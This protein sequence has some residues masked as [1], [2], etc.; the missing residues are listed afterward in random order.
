MSQDLVIG[1]Y[2]GTSRFS[3]ARQEHISETSFLKSDFEENIT[4]KLLSSTFP[5]YQL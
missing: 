5:Q 4:T 3:R 1:I 2:K